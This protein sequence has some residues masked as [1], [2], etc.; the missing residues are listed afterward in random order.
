MSSTNAALT[1]MAN[2][3]TDGATSN[4][5]QATTNSLTT[6]DKISFGVLQA[7]VRGPDGRTTL[8]K[9]TGLRMGRKINGEISGIG[10]LKTPTTTREVSLTLLPVGE[11]R[12]VDISA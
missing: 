7:Y 6:G 4:S 2:Y 5:A 8:A 12:A 3:G 11:G 9:K 10:G 1:A